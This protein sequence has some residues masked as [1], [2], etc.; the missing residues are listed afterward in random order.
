ML[1]ASNNCSIIYDSVITLTNGSI[2]M[3]KTHNW[4]L[5]V[6]AIL[7]LVSLIST[8][9]SKSLRAI[10]IIGYILAV[11]V[12]IILALINKKKRGERIKDLKEIGS[13]VKSKCQ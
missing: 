9:F 5:I 8:V 13:Y 2:E 12:I 4:V 10:T 3:M 6:L 1:N 7:G 11:P